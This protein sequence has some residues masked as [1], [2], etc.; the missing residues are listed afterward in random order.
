MVSKKRSCFVI[1]NTGADNATTVTKETF[2]NPP[3]KLIGIAEASDSELLMYFSKDILS[4]PQIFNDN[5]IPI[6]RGEMPD[7]RLVSVD[8]DTDPGGIALWYGSNN[9]ALVAKCKDVPTFTNNLCAKEYV[10]GTVTLSGAAW[11]TGK[12]LEV[13]SLVEG[14]PVRYELKISMFNRYSV[15]RPLVAAYVT[16]FIEKQKIYGLEMRED[17][18]GKTMYDD[19]QY[20]IGELYL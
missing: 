13:C 17:N 4:T 12:A 16:K 10:L 3:I 1:S 9:P 18:H 2:V 11:F 6:L 19:R 5:L 8:L 15:A 7:W 14:L 20:Y